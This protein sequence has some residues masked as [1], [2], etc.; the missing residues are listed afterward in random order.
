VDRPTEATP[1]PA[2]TAGSPAAAAPVTAEPVQ[3]WRL[4]FARDPVSAE[5]V[6]RAAMDAWQETL[7]AGGLP[8]A[9]LE[10]GGAG[11]ARFALAAPLP[12]AASGLA[13]L[14][15]IWLLERRPAW[16]VREALEGRMPPGHRYV[17]VENV[18]LGA[19]PLPGQVVAATWSVRLV[20]P[21]PRSEALTAA[22][23]ELLAASTLPRVRVR[24]GGDRPYD[25][26][27][28][29]DDV[30]SCRADELA[31]PTLRI[32]TR[33]DPALGSGRPEEVVAAIGDILGVELAI[34]ALVR[35]NLILADPQRAVPPVRPHPRRGPSRP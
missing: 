34:A 13:E 15:D 14:A 27:P 1:G 21:A 5:L 35:E 32:V 11:R 4:T 3:R 30:G 23:R 2:D 29:V 20:D 8:L 16:A 19:P 25:L 9:G 12:A 24:G 22:A 33:F 17:A 6:G 26:R 28:L 7:D 10:T 31:T 18:W